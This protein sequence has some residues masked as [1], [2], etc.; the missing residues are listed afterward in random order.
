MGGHFG[1]VQ[2]ACAVFEEDLRVDPAQADQVDVDGIRQKIGEFQAITLEHSGASCIRDLLNEVIQGI[3]GLL[4]TNH[5]ELIKYGD[6][7]ARFQR[8]PLQDWRFEVEK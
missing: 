3:S 1:D 7:L 8:N 5:G 2:P 4:D 6:A